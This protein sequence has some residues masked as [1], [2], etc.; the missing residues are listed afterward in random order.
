[1]EGGGRG[2]RKGGGGS[3]GGKGVGNERGRFLKSRRPDL[4]GG[5]AKAHACFYPAN[6]EHDMWF[7][8]EMKGFRSANS[9]DA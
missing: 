4:R 9:P 2:G 8:K 1:M 5:D 3:G 6:M 7:A